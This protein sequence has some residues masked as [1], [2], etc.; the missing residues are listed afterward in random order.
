M[1]TIILIISF[2]LNSINL[3]SQIQEWVYN[4][5]ARGNYEYVTDM[6][7]TSSGDIYICGYIDDNTQDYLIAKFSSSGNLLWWKLWDSPNQGTDKA[8]S[9]TLDNS[10]NV[11]VTGTCEI[12]GQNSNIGTVKY[13]SSGIF[14]WATIYNGPGQMGS[15]DIAVDVAVDNIGYVYVVGTERSWPNW[16]VTDVRLIK[17][18]ANGFQNTTVN[19]GSIGHDY[20]GKIAIDRVGGYL[21]VTAAVPGYYQNPPSISW[22]YGIYTYKFDID[23]F[24]PVPLWQRRYD[25]PGDG[26]DYPID[27]KISSAGKIVVAGKSQ[28]LNYDWDYAL[29]SLDPNLGQ[30]EDE[31]GDGEDFSSIRYNGPGS[32]DD[33]PSSLAVDG[34]G[35]VII[36]GK[37]EGIGTG[38]DY[39]TIR[40]NYLLQQ[41]WINRYNGNSSLN[42][43]GS[44]VITDALNNVYVTGTINEDNSFLQGDYGTIKYNSLGNQ[45]W[46]ATYSYSG[47]NDQ[48]K[49]IGVDLQNKIYV[50]GNEYRNNN[51]Y[52]IGI[53][54]YSDS[55]GGNGDDNFTYN[56]SNF[57]N[58]FNPST[59]IIFEIPSN[60]YISLKIYDILGKEIA[61]LIDNKYY[62]K[63]QHSISFNAL[64]LPSGVYLYKLTSS[65][66]NVTKKMLLVK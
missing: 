53:L 52:K 46:L 28:S 18:Y 61:N 54:K 33:I 37:S 60:D 7:V 43:N 23:P 47:N 55:N 2:A 16:L 3:H 14:Q 15:D 5:N 39:A 6:E 8:V 20:A 38:F 13:N 29:I 9:L 4:T 64:N 40:Y 35:G 1:K 24:N 57:P 58:P 17:Y 10:G 19:L 45:E 31:D 49:F 65:H 59:S 11:I 30:S 26:D 42:D 22:F 27:I 66:L 41:T 32:G 51:N 62:Q 12:Y 48:G 50:S 56:I 36:T 34:N 44:S 63:G 25:G 21:Y